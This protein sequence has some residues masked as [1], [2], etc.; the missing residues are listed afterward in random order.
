[1]KK[2]LN[3]SVLKNYIILL[4]FTTILEGA[5]RLISGLPLFEVS[6][7]RIFIGLNFI[8]LLLAFLLSWLNKTASKI[9]IIV[10]C[11]LFSIYAFFQMGFNNFIGVYASV[12]ASSQLGA[13]VD[14][15]MDF[16]GS[17][18]WQYYLE[19]I[20]FVLLVLYYIFLDKKIE[21]LLESGSRR[22]DKK[23]PI[24]RCVVSGVLLVV[25]GAIYA[26]TLFVKFMQNDLQMVSNKEL[27]HYP[28]VPSIAVNNFG[29]LGFGVL[30]IKSLGVDLPDGDIINTNPTNPNNP[31]STDRAFDDTYWKELIEKETDKELND[32]NKYL[33]NR[34]IPGFNDHTGMFKGKNLIVLMLESVNDII[35]NKDLYPNFY[36]MYTEGISMRNNYSPRN[37]C[38]TGNNEFSGMTGLYTIQNNCTSNRYRN[39]EYFTGLFNLFNNAGY[40]TSSM[41]NYTEQYYYRR[42]I[43]PNI[44][45]MKYYGVEDLGIPY[46]TE[47]TNWSSDEDFANKAMDITLKDTSKPF[48]LWMTT[49]SSH[50]PYNR[51]SVESKRYYSITDGLSY[52]TDTKR[53]MAK[54]KIVDNALGILMKRLEEAGQLENTVFAMYADHYPYAISKT[55]V[56]KALDYDLSGYEVDRTPMVIYNAGMKPEIVEKY[57]S[58]MTLTPTLANLFGLDYDPRL[59]FGQD[60]FSKDYVDAVIFDDG[61]WRNADVYYDAGKGNVK[62]YT[63]NKM[64]IEDIKAINNMISNDRKVNTSIIKNNYFEYLK[65]E[66]DDIKKAHGITDTQGSSEA[67]NPDI[68]GKTE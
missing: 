5:F 59:Y 42:T 8:S 60:I 22:K 28:S 15:I 31:G 45:S 53:F 50:Q 26:G 27:F 52:P 33:I 16:F 14:Y 7:I 2:L 49:V 56:G 68:E 1:M 67:S 30:D 24:I 13:V 21:K 63:E 40:N 23:E 12:N 6:F 44:G 57:S 9:I 46:R 39:N 66:L 3:N 41:H 61:S 64:S 20:P 35:I 65:D 18:L 55:N 43:H 37:N 29:V 47:Y 32:I 34:S 58:Y 54:L 25:V 19:F 48:M 38:S 10:L 11:L 17:F 36:K 51:D 62:Y 4:V